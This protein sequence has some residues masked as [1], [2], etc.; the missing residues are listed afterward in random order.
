M[1]QDSCDGHYSCDTATGAK[2]CNRGYS[3][4]QCEIPDL[5]LVGCT[6]QQGKD[7]LSFNFEDLEDIFLGVLF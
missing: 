2:I 4:A 6:A 5:S 7:K 1:P 3:G